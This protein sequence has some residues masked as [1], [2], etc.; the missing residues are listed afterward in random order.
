MENFSCLLYF[1]HCGVLTST[2]NTKSVCRFLKQTKKEKK[3]VEDYLNSL[4][5]AT[6]LQNISSLEAILVM[7]VNIFKDNGETL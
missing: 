7:C 5:L 6:I 3:F 2:K 4:M 1:T